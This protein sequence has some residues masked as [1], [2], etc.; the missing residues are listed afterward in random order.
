[1]LGGRMTRS[2]R[3][4]H[5]A[6]TPTPPRR[7][8]SWGDGR[9]PEGLAGHRQQRPC[10][11]PRPLLGRQGASNGGRVRIGRACSRD[12]LVGQPRRYTLWLVLRIRLKK[13]FPRPP[14]AT[15]TKSESQNSHKGI[16]FQRRAS[17]SMASLCS[18]LA[19]RSAAPTHS[20]TPTDNLNR[21][22]PRQRYSVPHNIG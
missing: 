5:S 7:S 12:A 3:V 4:R 6:A 2:L 14:Y 19:M 18:G 11:P 20:P 17:S 8:L 1:M 22:N 21:A 16:L 9:C 15:R 10:G 13:P